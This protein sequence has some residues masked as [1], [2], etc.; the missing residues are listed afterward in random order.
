MPSTNEKHDKSRNKSDKMQ[1]DDENIGLACALETFSEV[2]E[3]LCMIDSLKLVYN[4]QLSVIEKAYERY[5]YILDQY[6]EQPHLL[7]AH[8]DSILYKLCSIVRNLE[9][10]EDLRNLAFKYMYVIIKVRGY[11]IVVRHLPHEV[12]LKFKLNNKH[13]TSLCNIL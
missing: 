11:K 8:I 5:L 13:E 3:V 10:H 4:A 12:S 2:E 7:D 1:A 6:H 9:N